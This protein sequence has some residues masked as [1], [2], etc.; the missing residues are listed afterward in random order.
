VPPAEVADQLDQPVHLVVRPGDVV[1]AAEVDPLD[2]LQLG[3]EALLEHGQGALQRVGPELAESVE[4]QPAQP[5]H[6]IGPELAA[7]H[8]Q[9]RTGRCWIVERHGHLRVLRVDPHP[10][11]DAAGRAHHPAQPLPLGE[12][13][14]DDVVGQGQDRAQLGPLEGRGVDMDLL[15]HLLAPEP[16]LGQRAGRDAG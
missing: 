15:V 5:L 10:G 3:G 8:A 9:A 6:A 16:R 12:G 4:M 14:E 1:T 2:S 11:P 13:V 7:R